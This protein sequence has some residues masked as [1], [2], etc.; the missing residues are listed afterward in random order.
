MISS[1]SGKDDA[2]CPKCKGK[3]QKA[4][5]QHSSNSVF[6]TFKCAECEHTEMK[7]EGMLPEQQRY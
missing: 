5:I 3:M 1:K 4:G 6:V 7:C 2:V